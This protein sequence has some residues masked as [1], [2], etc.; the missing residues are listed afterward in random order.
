MTHIWP[1]FLSHHPPTQQQRPPPPPP[2]QYQ[3]GG[4]FK[5]FFIFIP[6]FGGFMIPIL[7]I[8]IFFQMGGW[9]KRWFN[10]ST[11]NS[12]RSG[13]LEER[14]ELVKQELATLLRLVTWRLDGT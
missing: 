12:P 7:T 5:H 13:Y 3:L 9:L 1:G 6:K 8:I 2:P 4:G 11:T 10:G 14:D